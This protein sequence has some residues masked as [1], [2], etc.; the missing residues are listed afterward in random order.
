MAERDQLFIPDKAKR[1][2]KSFEF[3]RVWSAKD[4]QHISVLVSAF[5]DPVH[6]GIML[7]DLAR[8]VAN[9][10]QD[11]GRDRTKTLQRIKAGFYAEFE[12]PTD[13]PMTRRAD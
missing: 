1:D 7:A 10:Y 8:H 4:G 5:D 12:S 13:D 3:L 6:W 11:Q 9:A 2:P